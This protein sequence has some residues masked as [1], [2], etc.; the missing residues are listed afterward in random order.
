MRGAVIFTLP[1]WPPVPPETST[2]EPTLKL[3]LSGVSSNTSEVVLISTLPPASPAKV[4]LA[5]SLAVFSKVTPLPA[6]KPIRLFFGA[7]ATMSP[8]TVILPASALTT[9]SRAFNAFAPVPAIVTSP[10]CTRY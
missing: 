10:M 3:S 5:S 9:V 7:V 1:P 4:L 2:F 6:C 8:V